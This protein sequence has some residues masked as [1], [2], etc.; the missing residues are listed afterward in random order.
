M[1]IVVIWSLG[2]N[3]TLGAWNGFWR[4]RMHWLGVGAAA[5]VVYLVAHAA[6]L[7]ALDAPPGDGREMFSLPSQQIARVVRDAPDSLTDADRNAIARYYPGIDV[8]ASYEFDRADAVK[9]QLDSQALAATPSDYLNLWLRL[10]KDHP[11][12]YLDTL[13][14]STTGYWY[15]G[16]PY[17]AT[18]SAYRLVSPDDWVMLVNRP[19]YRPGLTVEQVDPNLGSDRESVDP[20][21]DA[22]AKEINYRLPQLP[23]IGWAFSIGAW[24]WAAV[25]LT[26]VVI[27]RRRRVAA[28][29]VV[30]QILVWGTAMISPVYAEARYSLP[31]LAMLPLLLAI[32]G[33]ARLASTRLAARGED[34]AVPEVVAEGADA[35]GHDLRV[36]MVETTFDGISWIWNP[37]ASR[38]NRPRSRRL[39]PTPTTR[40]RENEPRKNRA[41]APPLGIIASADRGGGRRA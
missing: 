31:M 11:A 16:A 22:L 18:G 41:R 13:L 2:R 5:T 14:A 15:P 26:A 21:R 6:V 28:P 10:G 12:S 19:F 3:Q 30:L 17:K 32:A 38:E 39:I 1:L 36:T 4:R 35:H 25:V 27:L 29:V 24:T 34:Q 40:Y 37:T 20:R 7:T 8:G 33:S 9:N 23:I